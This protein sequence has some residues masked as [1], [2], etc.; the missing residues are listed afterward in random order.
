MISSQVKPTES[1]VI[2]IK[3]KGFHPLGFEPGSSAMTF[4]YVATRLFSHGNT[5]GVNIKINNNKHVCH[6]S[7]CQR[8]PAVVSS[9]LNTRRS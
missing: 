4:V 1:Y 2:A 9:G 8:Q 5:M 3:E 7:Q 6:Q